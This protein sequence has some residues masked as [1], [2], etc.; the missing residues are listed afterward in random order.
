MQA[1]AGDPYPNMASE[2]KDIRRATR[3]RHAA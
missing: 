1:S 2:E 3:K